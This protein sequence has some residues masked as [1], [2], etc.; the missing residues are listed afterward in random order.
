[1]NEEPKREPRPTNLTAY[2]YPIQSF[3]LPDN[4]TGAKAIRY[5][6]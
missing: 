1:M 2:C 6:E 4:R 5:N 3:H